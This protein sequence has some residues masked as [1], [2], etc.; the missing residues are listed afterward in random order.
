MFNVP[1]QHRIKYPR[2]A[3]YYSDRTF[4]N[5]GHFSIQFS[6][7]ST[8]FCMASDGLGWEHVSVHMVTDGKPRTPTWAEMC[9]VKD[10]FWG[11]DD[12]V[13]QY[14]PPESEYVN[15]HKH[16][17]HLWRSTT[18]ELPTPMSILVGLK[19]K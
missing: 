1:E 16:T 15:M 7:R 12:W 11:T 4:G 19:K 2:N 18:H 17:L 9:K 13:V 3:P 6:A 5:N 14:H 10:L 8:A